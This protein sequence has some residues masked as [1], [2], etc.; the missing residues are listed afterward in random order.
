[1]MF[2]KKCLIEPL[3]ITA[4]HFECD[5]C[6]ASVVVPIKAGVS[7]YVGNAAAGSC[8]FCHTPWGISP[9]SEEHKT[10]FAFA[11]SLEQVAGKMEGRHLKLKLEIKCPETY[12]SRASSEKD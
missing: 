10:I 5:N 2:E 7:S 6:H 3:D 11:Q 8:Q 9:Q 1:M 4:V 12:A